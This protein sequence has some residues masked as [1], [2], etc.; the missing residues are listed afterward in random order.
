MASRLEEDLCCPVCHD[1]FRDPVVLLCSHSF[2]KDCVESWWKDKEVKECPVCKRRS[3]KEQPPCNLALKNLSETFLQERDQSSSHALCSQHSEKLRLFCLDHQQPVCLICRDSEKHTDHRFRPIDEAAPQHKKQLQE[4]LE[5]LKKKLQSFERVKVEFEQTAEHI[6][7]QAGLTETQIKEQFKKLHQFLEEEEEARMAA[8]REEEEQKSRMMKENIE[9]LSRDVKSLSDTIR[10]TEDEL[11]AEDV[12]FLL[13]Y[14]AAVER[15]QQHPLLDDPQLAPGALIDEA[16]HLGNLSFNIWNKMKDVVSYSPVVLD[17]TSARPGLVLSEDL[18][19]WRLGARQKLPDNPERAAKSEM[20]MKGQLRAL[21]CH[22]T[23]DLEPGRNKR[24]NLLRIRDKLQDIGTEGGRKWLG[25]IYNLQGYVHFQL[26]SIEEARSFFSRAEEAF[27]QMRGAEEGPWLVVTYGNQAWLHHHQGEEAES[28]AC[29]S[30]IDVLTEDPSQD[31]LHPE[32]CAE[33][34]W[35]LMKFS[36]EQKLLAADYFQRAI[37]MQPDVVEWQSSHVILL[38]NMS[39]HSRAVVKEDIMVKLRRAK[40]QDPENLYLAATYFLQLAKK[41][42]PDQ[43][44]ARELKEKILRNPVS[45]YSGIKP[46][47]WFYKT[48]ISMDEAVALAEEALKLHPDE[49]YL[50]RC[51]ALS[52]KWKIWEKD[53]RPSQSL[54]EKGMRAH[55]EL[56]SLYPDSPFMKRMDLAGIYAKSENTNTKAKAEEIFQQLLVEDLE[57]DEQQVVFNL[58]AKH[59]YFIQQQPNMS[60]QYHMKA[61]EIPIKSY[62]QKNSIQ[63]LEKIRYKGNQEVDRFLSRLKEFQK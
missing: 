34:A 54:I 56:L 16:K 29:L 6:K 2:C 43:S 58:Y 32:I 33:K 49:R 61:V 11:R 31:E 44:G 45:S 37:R 60:I 55:E 36:R 41:G 19:S 9:S 8:L 18:T 38:V 15:V 57:P 12:S 14:K 13:N 47:L 5:P 20:T 48:F 10:T 7:V 17:P 24:I 52:Y 26:G 21:Q 35:T 40:E 53:S 4:T 50:K 27:R 51:V 28:R 62:F 42:K 25:H 1:V 59:L 3:S 39:E 30:K 46:L 23:W 22:F 63:F